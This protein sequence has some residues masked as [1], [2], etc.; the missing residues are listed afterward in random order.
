M[1]TKP[2][3]FIISVLFFFGCTSSDTVNKSVSVSET[4]SIKKL[5]S[6]LYTGWYFIDN[7]R[8][9]E[10][11]LQQ[12]NSFYYIN[13]IPIV[14]VKHFKEVNLFHEKDCFALFIWLDNE[15]SQL[16]NAARKKSKGQK[17]A[18]IINNKLEIIQLADDPQ[19][20]QVSKDIDSR[21]YGQVLAFPCKSRS[22]EELKK[23]KTIIESEK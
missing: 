4:S 9:R 11:R 7:N 19:F 5:D 16:L 8:G 20:A 6:I 18:F 14:A 23:F 10:R 3:L 13:P 22:S 17:F 12:T 15:G 1:T 2:A 21:V